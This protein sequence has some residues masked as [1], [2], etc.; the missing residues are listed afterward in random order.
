MLKVQHLFATTCI[1]VDQPQRGECIITVPDSLLEELA[2][3]RIRYALLL[4][5]YKK[6]MQNSSEAQEKFVETVPTVL[7]RPLSSERNFQSH[8]NTLINEEVS[9]F[10]I[11]Y[12]KQFCVVFPEDVW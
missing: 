6:E 7:G 5:R 10:N 1:N 3:L 12:L 2:A 4:S 9:L 11:T 8:F